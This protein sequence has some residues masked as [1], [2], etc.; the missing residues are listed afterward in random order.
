MSFMYQQVHLQQQNKPFYFLDLI[1]SWCS[2]YNT[3]NTCTVAS[4][5][6]ILST[7]WLSASSLSYSSLISTVFASWL[8]W[9]ISLFGAC[10]IWSHFLV[11]H[12]MYCR[13]CDMKLQM[14]K[15][16]TIVWDSAMNYNVHTQKVLFRYSK[17]LGRRNCHFKMW[18]NNAMDFI[19]APT[20]VN[21]YIRY[22][23]FFIFVHSVLHLF[24]HTAGMTTSTTRVYIWH[25]IVLRNYVGKQE[26]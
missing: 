18:G 16:L 26:N 4:P 6:A 20:A 9:Y 15:G 14:S 11:K 3:C 8:E 12:V 2:K 10:K 5:N 24:T 13:L 22:T 19:T 23:L 21:K 25:S 1:M 7:E 17:C